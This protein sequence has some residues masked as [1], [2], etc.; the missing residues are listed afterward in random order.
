MRLATS[1]ISGTTVSDAWLRAVTEVPPRHRLYHLVTQI[2]QPGEECPEIRNAVNWISDQLGYPAIQTVANTIFPHDLAATCTNHEELADRYLAMYDKIQGLDKANRNGTYFGRLVD[3]PSPGGSCNQLA[4][5]VRKL[6]VELALA[7]PK[8]ARYELN[9]AQPGDY[10]D[11]MDGAACTP[12]ESQAC[13]AASI[14][15]AGQDNSPRG[16]PCL[17][18]CSFQLDD[19]ALHMVAHYRHQHLIERGYGNY[20][21]LGHLLSYVSDAVEAEV[22]A[23]TIVAGVAVVDAAQYRIYELERRTTSSTRSIR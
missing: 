17:S 9:I 21:G 2:T 19:G 7:G 23:L 6:K 10:S 20:L 8:S 4:S 1:M 13:Q 22:G 14:Y 12:T 11:S 15:A 5:L 18:F 3:Y 16:F